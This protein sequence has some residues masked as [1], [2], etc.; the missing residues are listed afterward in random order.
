MSRG[1]IL[2]AVLTMLGAGLLLIAA[3]GKHPYGFYMVLRLAITIGAVCWA[4]ILY[5]AGQRGWTWIF[6]TVALLLNPFFPI[7]MRREDWQPI[8]LCLGIFAIGW[9]GYWLSRKKV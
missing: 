5:K 9:S 6:I 8:D 2:E 7:H 4:W 1:Q 3:A